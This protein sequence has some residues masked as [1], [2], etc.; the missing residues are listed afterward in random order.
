MRRFVCYG[1]SSA[2]GSLLL[3]LYPAIAGYS[4]RQLSSS[5]VNCIRIRRTSDN[6]ELD[7]GF[8]GGVV[9]TASAIAFVA[10]GGHGS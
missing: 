9:D 10:A 4:L 3:D 5:A 2:G 6:S 8:V 1:A 7:I